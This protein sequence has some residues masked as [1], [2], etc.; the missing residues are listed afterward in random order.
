MNEAHEKWPILGEDDQA[1][2]KYIQEILSTRA[3]GDPYGTDGE[4]GRNL[5]SLPLGLRAMAATHWLDISLT[6]DSITWHF[7][8]FGET[9]LVAATEAALHELGLEELATCFTDAKNLMLPAL[10]KTTAADNDLNELLDRLGIDEQASTLNKRAWDLDNL[11]SG[12]SV[13][14]ESWIRYTRQFPERVF[15][16]EQD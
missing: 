7:L 8:N 6:L 2:L 1:L 16:P 5:A 12:R 4:F 11:G 3:T 13:I 14:Y 9:N 10:A 15:E